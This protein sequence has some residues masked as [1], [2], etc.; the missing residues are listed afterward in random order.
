M[1]AEISQVNVN[2]ETKTELMLA[3]KAAWHG[4]GTIVA[5]APNSEEAIK[6]AHLDWEVQTFPAFGKVGEEI[7]SVPEES[8]MVS[9]RMDTKGYLGMVSKKYKPLQNL[10]AFSFMDSLLMDGIVKYETAGALFGGR[11][12]WLLAKMPGAQQVKGDDTVERY[13]LLT[14]SHDGSECVNVLP[15]TVRVVCWNTYRMALAGAKSLKIAHVGDIDKKAEQARQVLGLASHNFEAY[16]TVA[17]KMAET[18]VKVGNTDRWES[19]IDEVMPEAGEDA[20]ERVADLIEERRNTIHRLF[21]DDAKQN[22]KGIEGTAWAAYNAVSEY[23][24]HLQTFR[25]VNDAARRESRFNNV[26]FGGG[27]SLKAKAWGA[28]VRKFEVDLPDEVLEAAAVP[29]GE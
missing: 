7:I 13:M 17:R 14:N 15:T 23:A 12:V 28:A 3:G 10:K 21:T 2:G 6:L 22:L 24:D 1:S 8:A 26:L 25:G 16:M 11:K 20:T 4:L 5:E 9:V 19:F 29:A 27:H 18:P